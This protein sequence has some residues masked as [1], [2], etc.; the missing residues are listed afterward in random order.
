MSITTFFFMDKFGKYCQILVELSTYHSVAT[1]PV[2][3]S[4]RFTIHGSL[5]RGAALK[6]KSIMALV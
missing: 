2:F 5:S 3:S 4:I 6:L 1:V